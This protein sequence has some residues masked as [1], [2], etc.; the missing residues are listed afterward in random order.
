[1]RRAARG[2]PTIAYTEYH[3]HPMHTINFILRA[4]CVLL[5]LLAAAATVGLLPETVGPALRATA[6]VFLLVHAGELLVFFP[7]VR[8]YQG[9]LAFSI[10]LTLLFGLLHWL[11]LPARDQAPL[12]K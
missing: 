6:L 9:P 8:R 4:L 3:S 1:M 10:V 5:Y 12:P 7:R 11:P 2:V